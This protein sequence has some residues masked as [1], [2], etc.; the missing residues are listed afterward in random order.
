MAQAG[1]NARAWIGTIVFL[2]VA[3]GVVA[4][5]IPW[6]ISRWRWY[7]WGG[8][9]WVVPVAWAAVSSGVPSPRPSHS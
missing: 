3:P 8:A 4:G 1:S 2:F 9:G 6:L 5:L 7:N